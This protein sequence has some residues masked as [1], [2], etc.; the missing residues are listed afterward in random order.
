[1][2]VSLHIAMHLDASNRRQFSDLTT[3]PR[4]KPFSAPPV[5]QIE[6]TVISL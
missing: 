4:N 6:C 2:Y 1:M 3:R 5:T